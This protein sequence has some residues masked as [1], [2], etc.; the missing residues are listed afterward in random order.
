MSV[1]ALWAV[2]EGQHSCSFVQDLAARGLGPGG[3]GEVRSRIDD[4]PELFQEVV[5]NSAQPQIRNHLTKRSTQD[6]IARRTGTS[7]V[8][9][10]RYM[11][12]G[13]A[14]ADSEDKPLCLKVTPGLS[15]SEVGCGDQAQKSHSGK[16]SGRRTSSLAM[17]VRCC[18]NECNLVFLTWHCTISQ[19]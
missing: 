7:V 17:S 16:C 9:R 12:P 18:G 14:P 5:I 3:R 19:C 13:V 15:K 11:P 10:G 8:V 6:D 4:A 1:R 2:A